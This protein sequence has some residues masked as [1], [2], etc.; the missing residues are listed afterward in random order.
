MCHWSRR[1]PNSFISH[2]SAPVHSPSTQFSRSQCS[3][4]MLS[5]LHS[6]I[7]ACFR[8]AF[9]CCCGKEEKSFFVG[10][11]MGIYHPLFRKCNARTLARER[12]R[13]E[14]L[15]V[16][17]AKSKSLQMRS[18]IGVREA[19]KGEIESIEQSFSF[20]SFFFLAQKLPIQGW[21]RSIFHGWKHRLHELPQFSSVVEKI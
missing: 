21:W 6:H 8:L 7:Y 12:Q 3:L 2:F 13:W 14:K 9:C 10:K 20:G 17:T 5:L 4:C 15:D 1:L 16:T 18:A 19:A 11:I